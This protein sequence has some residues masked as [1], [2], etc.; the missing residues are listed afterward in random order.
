MQKVGLSLDS[1][2]VARL[3]VLCSQNYTNRS[4]FITQLIVN[5]LRSI[6]FQDAFVR[7]SSAIDRAVDKGILS[8]D[9]KAEL[10]RIRQLSILKSF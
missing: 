2:L 7:A 6:E 10:E 1:D 9:D 5:H 4:A 3:D 8:A